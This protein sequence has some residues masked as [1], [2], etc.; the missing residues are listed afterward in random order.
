[1]LM[2]GFDGQMTTARNCGSASAARISGCGRASS[3][4][5]KAK[6]VTSG[7]Q[8]CRDEIALEVERA[9][10]RLHQVRT[11]SSVIGRIRRRCRTTR[12]CRR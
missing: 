3:A 9:V 4:P 8:R 5:A 7:A 2:N 11:G 6:P 1:M 10:S 12:R